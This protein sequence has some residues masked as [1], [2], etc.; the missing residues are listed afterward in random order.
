MSYLDLKAL[1]V[2]TDRSN[3]DKF[4]FSA[5]RLGYKNYDTETAVTNMISK[6]QDPAYQLCIIFES[7]ADKPNMVRLLNRLHTNTITKQ[8]PLM[9]ISDLPEVEGE[10]EAYYLEGAQIVVR[11]FTDAKFRDA[12]LSIEAFRAFADQFKAGRERQFRK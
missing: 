8:I 1:V 3:M 12:L 5:R 10:Q 7:Q 6:L 4:V 11:N 9:V 2:A